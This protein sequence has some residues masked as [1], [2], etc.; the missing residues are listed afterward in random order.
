MN[1]FLQALK[2]YVDFTGRTAR[3][4]FWM[5]ILIYS[6]ASISIDFVIYILGFA[7]TNGGNLVGYIFYLILFLP[8]LSISVRRLHDANFSGWWVL[9]PFISFF[10]SM[11]KGSSGRNKYGSAPETLSIKIPRLGNLFILGLGYTFIFISIIIIFGQL[12]ENNSKFDKEFFS[13]LAFISIFII[14]SL[15]IVLHKNF[16]LNYIAKILLPIILVVDVIFTF[17]ELDWFM[18]IPFSLLI[19]ASIYLYKEKIVNFKYFKKNETKI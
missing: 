17:I 2:Q 10:M 14:P 7:D 5:F 6:I 19:L 13:M 11:V 18:I 1:Y 9:L 8:L 16:K 15:Y 3:K 4:D 12:L